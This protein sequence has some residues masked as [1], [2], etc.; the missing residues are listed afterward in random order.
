MCL[1]VFKKKASVIIFGCMREGVTGDRENYFLWGIYVVVGSETEVVSREDL[2]QN[3]FS[4]KHKDKIVRVVP[5]NLFWPRVN[6]G[7][8][9]QKAFY[10]NYGIW[11]RSGNLS[12]R[13]FLL[14]CRWVVW[15]ITSSVHDYKGDA[16]VPEYDMKKPN[17]VRQRPPTLLP[18]LLKVSRSLFNSK[19][20]F[21]C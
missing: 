13:H 4:F 5:G 6:W 10:Q 9:K 18:N 19:S 11:Q 3:R 2:M 20:R 16:R 14:N 1:K 12:R 8:Y 17:L 21:C 15:I 7:I